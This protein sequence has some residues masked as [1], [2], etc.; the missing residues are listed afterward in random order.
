MKTG[1]RI[2]GMSGRNKTL[3]KARK[4]KEDEFYTRMEDV[5]VMMEHAKEHLQG[6]RVYLNCDSKESAF[7][8]YFKNNYAQHKLKRLTATG[9]NPDGKGS[10]IVYDG[11]KER[12]EELIGD[13]DF[14]SKECQKLISQHDIV[15]TN[16]PFSLSNDHLYVIL[17]NNIDFLYIG[18]MLDVKNKLV[19]NETVKNRMRIVGY[20]DTFIRK[21]GTTRSVGA[22]WY[23]NLPVQP[24]NISQIT[25][26]KT[27]K[28]TKY[29]VPDERSCIVVDNIN[30]VPTNYGGK[31]GVPV[32][33]AHRLSRDEWAIVG[34]IKPTR[35]GKKKYH[36]ILVKRKRDSSE[37]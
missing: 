9:Y 6:R 19:I 32:T 29:Y 16:P 8:Q 1:A 12:V 3:I 15:I 23:T 14:R 36:R 18:S 20:V 31:I 28:E 4:V 17:K 2:A 7:Y 33:G 34:E 5:E 24:M 22:Y 10:S 35:S 21:D 13:G 25:P 37:C 26:K 30:D 11:K 27:L